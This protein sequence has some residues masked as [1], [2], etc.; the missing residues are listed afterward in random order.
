MKQ[1]LLLGTLTGCLL[2]PNILPA[3]TSAGIKPL[4]RNGAPLNL[5]F[6]TGTLQDWTAEG[7][8]FRQQPV[9]GD[10]VSARR[11]DMK[12]QHQGDYW[13]G[14]FERDGDKPQGTLTSVSFP[15]AHPF[16]SF[17]VA[18]GS[19]E[20]TRVELVRA[21]NQQVVFKISGTDTED[22]RPVVV[23]LQTHIGK[24]IFI[25]LVDKES[26]G[27]GHINFDDFK[28]HTQRPV[29]PNA[30]DAARLAKQSEMPPPDI[31]KFA[32]T[33]PQQAVE[34]MTLPAGFKATMFAAE[35]DVQQPI[36]FALDDRGRLWVAEAYTYPNRAKEGE[37]KDRILVFEDTNG[38]GKFNRRTVFIEGLN[39]VSGIEVGFGGV[40]VGAAPHLLFIPI[41]DGDQP[42][43]AG[44]AKILLDGWGWQDTHETLN[45]FTWGPDGWLYGCHGVFTH[46][47]VGKP[48]APNS[49]R[50]RINA[51]VWRYHPTRHEFDVFAEGTSN[52]WGI[53]F[54]E[55][56]QCFIE[57]C[58]IPHLFHVI[59]GARYHRQSG[60]HFNPHIY[61]DIKTIADHVHWAGNRG[62]HA[63]NARSGEVGGGHAHAGLMIYKGDNWPEKYRG[64]IFIGN[65]HGAC[66]NMDT[67]ERRGSGFV[68]RH[69]PN[70]IEFNDKW[71]QVINF[72]PGPDGSVYFIDWY[73]KN[74]C[75]SNDANH[76]DRSN[77]R[78]FRVSYGEPKFQ[79]V[80]LATQ[81]DEAL[82][83]FTIE[84]GDW[85]GRH[86]RRLLQ[87][88]A[89]KGSQLSQK[90]L[91]RN[92]GGANALKQLRWLW[93]LHLTGGLHEPEL[94]SALR[95]PGE[96]VRA[97]AIQFASERQTL[98]ARL[99]N[100]FA[101]LAREDQSPVVRLYLASAMQRV[102]L[103][104]RWETVQ[105]LSQ[106]AE[107][108]SDH[109][110]PLMV[111]YAA[112]PL[113]AADFNRA[114][115]LA[116]ESKLPRM[117]EFTVRRTAAL[118]TPEA[119]AAITKTL[120]NASDDERRLQILS[121]LSTALK[122][123]RNV[124]MP[125][126]WEN[127]EAKL[128]ISESAEIRAQVQALSLTF[129]STGAL[130]SLQKALANPA[131]DLNVRR[132][133]LDSLL[134][135]RA[136]GLAP[137]LQSLL[138]EASLRV[139]ALRALASFDDPQTPA[140]ILS[141]YSSLN[142]AEKRDALN[143]LASREA[144]AKPLLAAVGANQVVTTDITADI[145][146]Q[147]RNLKSAELDELLTKVWGVARDSSA[148]KQEL[149]EKYRRIYRAGGSQPGD[150]LRGRVVYT[151]ICQQCHVLFDTGG[152]VGP[153][154][155]GSNRGDLDY[156]LQNMV[157]PNAVIPNDYRSSTIDLKDDRVL[158]GIVKEGTD[159]T[160]TIVTANE[161][162]VVARDE[163]QS[164][165]ESELSMMPE[166]LLDPLTDQEVRDLIYYLRQPAQAQLLATPDTI[167][168]F[169]N[170]KDLS[171]WDGNPD[172]WSVENGEIVGKSVTGLKHNEFLKSQ[173]VLDDFRLV[174][175]V[176]LLPDTENSGVQFRS[177]PFGEY[178]MKGLQADIG[179]GWWGKLYEENG[180]ALL[181]KK[182]GDP[183]VKPGDW[184]TYEILA[185]GSKIRTAINGN[186]CVDLDDP[187]AARR[188]I[189]GLQVHS[190]GP[191]EVRFKDFK[192]EINPT[193][194][195]LTVKQTGAGN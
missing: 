34:V 135:A 98:S 33:T 83:Q 133:A 183:F 168:F 139:A 54:D 15:V 89:Q 146:R 64:Q 99:L 163:I 102:P 59:Q 195:L 97:W 120:D 58:V 105:T 96:Y 71:S 70:P 175:Q 2:Q 79:P 25:R 166:G 95:Q 118:N 152:T 16:A 144:Y 162:L 172:V 62:P 38:D 114:L 193:F 157:D 30:L 100:E 31:L 122:G 48:G 160:L 94:L 86:A 173:L 147:L 20:D 32:G 155:T 127:V 68:G 184:N 44:E 14:T 13:I 52:P 9:K 10:T 24:D 111:W 165:H 176:K 90:V 117:L 156:L 45:T 23:D 61:D 189:I 129:G 93:A 128:A 77:G 103:A 116:A 3:Q 191:T 5:D 21:D 101:R 137:L 26:G 104:D 74:E 179:K 7:T 78:I 49:E 57:A 80:N 29:F 161:T 180:R 148:D 192:L 1:L 185:V 169:F 121:G 92:P 42:K 85:F 126:G 140:A 109:N 159:Q 18:G 186:L 28:F 138:P 171:Y 11:G 22:L 84:R 8:A 27:W 178:E 41:A 136:P 17:L 170:G 124:A 87:E 182:P 51:G 141:V 73:D 164:I 81:S 56:G 60:S 143:T 158:T 153:N 187:Q 149:I 106:R 115:N 150:A 91:A 145:I 154:L 174:F 142:T 119:F 134:Q 36:A 88:R 47:N 130:A 190:G 67:P 40:W 69:N 63:G 6:E 4:G 151:R 75:H 112:E 113:A 50:Q 53:D 108:A 107:D 39:L 194:D 12:S 55:N 181:W 46:S 19:H 177:E 72:L 123:Q 82:I 65:I 167:G 37:G 35:P 132:M 43:P 66:I 76:H 110:L 125:R 131:T 188:G